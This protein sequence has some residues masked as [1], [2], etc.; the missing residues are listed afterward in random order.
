[1]STVAITGVSGYIGQ[2]LLGL[3]EKDDSI[4]KV[5]GIDVGEPRA[6]PPKLAFHRL[7]IRDQSIKELLAGA[8]VLDAARPCALSRRAANAH[9]ESSL[10][11]LIEFRRKAAPH[12]TLLS[13]APT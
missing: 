6:R 13:S 12:L 11:R 10:L 7:D 1:M 5:I 4:E 9:H 2:Q 8:D 3:L